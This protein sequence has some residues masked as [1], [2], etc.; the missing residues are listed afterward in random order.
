MAKT[1]K[2]SYTWNPDKQE[3][4]LSLNHDNETLEEI[5]RL[6]GQMQDSGEEACVQFENA[7]NEIFL[8][9]ATCES[10]DYDPLTILETGINFA[11]A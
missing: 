5:S 6:S 2:E 7:W 1:T 3:W 8:L 11:R 4:E 9:R 10:T